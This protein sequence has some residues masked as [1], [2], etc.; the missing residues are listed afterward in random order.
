[1]TPDQ[2]ADRHACKSG[3]D[4]ASIDVEPPLFQ[5]LLDGFDTTARGG[6]R[7]KKNAPLVV[8]LEAFLKDAAAEWTSARKSAAADKPCS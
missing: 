7:V 1:M 8:R 5:L 3:F 6:E 2:F 4:P